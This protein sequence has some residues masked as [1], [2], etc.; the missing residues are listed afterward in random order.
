[1]GGIGMTTSASGIEALRNQGAEGI[2]LDALDA[3][4]VSGEIA[5]IRPDAIVD[6][7]TSLPKRYTPEEMRAAAPRDRQVRLEGG[8]NLHGAAVKY[9]VKR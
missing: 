9:G 3:K 7:L 6:E 4:S 5:K 8:G 2:I 1:M